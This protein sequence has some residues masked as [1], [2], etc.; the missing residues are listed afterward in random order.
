MNQRIATIVTSA[1]AFA[2]LYPGKHGDAI[3]TLDATI[4][5]AISHELACNLS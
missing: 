5:G 3:H 2:A 4:G 1:G